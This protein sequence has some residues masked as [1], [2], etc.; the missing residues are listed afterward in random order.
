[1]L[2]I[3]KGKEGDLS[4]AMQMHN[5]KIMAHVSDRM[6]NQKI[7]EGNYIILRLRHRK[8]RQLAQ[9]TDK[10]SARDQQNFN[11]VAAEP[12]F[13]TGETEMIEVTT[14]V[15]SPKRYVL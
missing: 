13:V 3:A 14:T 11:A 5:D 8:Q 10:K 6:E 2:E 15:N 1:M 9:V 7:L 4:E 12:F